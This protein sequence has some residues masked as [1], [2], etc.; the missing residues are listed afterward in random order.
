MKK[1][2]DNTKIGIL[3]FH[4]AVNYGAVLQTYALS[5]FIQEKLSKDCEVINYTCEKFK[6]NYKIFRVYNKNLKGIISAVI[7]MPIIYF[8]NRKFQLFMKKNV[9]LSKEKY[10]IKNINEANDK[11]NCF[12]TGSDQVWNLEL[13]NDNTYF[14]DF[15][16]SQNI[17]LSY[18]ASCGK[19]KLSGNAIKMNK[20]NLKQYKKITV[21]ESTLKDSLSTSLKIEVEKVLDP[22]F[23]IEQNDWKNLLSK[24][25]IRAEKYILIYLLHEKSI[26]RIAEKIARE[27]NLKI[28]SIQNSFDKPINADYKLNC[29]IEEFLALIKNAEYVVT[30][31]FHGAAFSVIFRK[32]LKIVFKKEH[33]ELNSRLESLINDFKLESFLISDDSS[34]ELLTRK[35]DYDES[36]INRKISQSKE[37]L[38]NMLGDRNDKKN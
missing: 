10:N 21:R 15:V 9:K 12:I 18:A 28:I 13:T 16:S 27:K 30:D 37:I 23:L 19:N 34:I 29:G 31:S 7:K 32:Q 4:N 3:T 8:K 17:K 26:Y 22:V 20:T 2:K 5:T 25:S 14:L 11:Y 35:N 38:I 6:N 1:E 33:S 24:K 36:L